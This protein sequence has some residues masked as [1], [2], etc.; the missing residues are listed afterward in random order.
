[1]C[2]RVCVCITNQNALQPVVEV[3]HVDDSALA[4]L[5]QAELLQ[6]VVMCGH[7]PT[8]TFPSVLQN[9]HTHRCLKPLK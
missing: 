9:T 4:A 1:M 8:V 6:R 2:A 3:A 5:R 7:L